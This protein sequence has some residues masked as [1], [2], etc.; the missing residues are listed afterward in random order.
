M[1][2]I[3]VHYAWPHIVRKQYYYYRHYYSPEMM[4]LLLLSFRLPALAMTTRGGDNGIRDVFIV[5][6]S[7]IDDGASVGRGNAAGKS[8]T[9]VRFPVGGYRH[10]TE[11]DYN[12]Y[13]SLI[14]EPIGCYCYRLALQSWETRFVSTEQRA[15]GILTLKDCTNCIILQYR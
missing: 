6:I 7:V 8:G 13:A 2:T 14:R 4:I 9:S 3:I 1:Y 11:M 10:P 15:G 12:N 5:F